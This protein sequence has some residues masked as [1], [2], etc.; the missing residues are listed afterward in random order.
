MSRGLRAIVGVIA[1]A[2]GAYF[3]QPWLVRIGVSL[4]LGAALEKNPSSVRRLQ[5]QSVMI[6]SAVQPQEIVYGR[7]R[8][9]GVLAW[10]DTSGTTNEYL[11][12]VIAV[13]EHEIDGYEKLWI[14]ETEIDIATEIDGSGY[15]TN[16]AFINADGTNLVKTG[17]YTGGPSQTADAELIAAFADWDS[18]KQGNDVAYFWVRLELDRSEGGTD[19][20][21][22]DANV[23]SQG[24]P[25]DLSVTL[26]GARVYDP[27][28]DSTQTSIPGA[29]THRADTPSTWEWSDNS[30][31]CRADY[32][33]HQRFGPGYAYTDIDWLTVAE[34]A[35]I[36]DELVDIPDAATQKRYTLNGVVSTVDNPKAIIESMA[37]ADHGVTLL[38]PDGIKLLVGSWQASSYT[39]DGSWLAGP[40]SVQSALQTDDA[41]N[42]VRG[43]Y[44]SAADNYALVEFAPRTASAY[45]TED[46]VGRIWSDIVL[47]F[48]NE[49]Y[50]AQRSAIIELK[51]S[52]QQ[53]TVTMQCNFR[54]MQIPLYSVVALDMEGFTLDT[55]RVIGKSSNQ[56]G[57]V[58]LQLREEVESDWTYTVPDLAVPPI[59]PTVTRNNGSPLPPTGLTASTVANG[60]QLGWTNA[61]M[62]GVSHIE[63]YGGTLN[64]RPGADLLTKTRSEQYLHIL[65]EGTVRYYWILARSENG[66]VSPWEPLSATGGVVGTAGAAGVDGDDALRYYI[67]PISGTAILNGTG[68]LTVEAHLVTGGVDAHLAA[69][70][71]KL[72][73]GTT[74]VTVANGYATGSDG[75]TG[76]FDAGDINGAAVVELKDGPAGTVLDTITLVDVYD[77]ADGDPGTAGEDAVYGY[78]TPS[79]PL[80][81]T[82]ASDQTT[83]TPTATTVDLTATFVLAGSNVAVIS[84]RI[85]RTAAGI[86]TGAPVTLGTE[87]NTARVTVVELD[88]T[89]Q[90][91]SV[92]FTYSFEGKT[93]VV[94]ETV[95][96]SMAGSKGDKGDTGDTGSIGLSIIQGTVYK[97]SATTPSTPSLGT[98]SYDF[99][100]KVLTPPS[101]WSASPPAADGNPMYATTTTFSSTDGAGTNDNTELWSTPTLFVSD[102]DDGVSAVVTQLTM[103]SLTVAADS[104]GT[105]YSLSALDGTNKADHEVFSGATNVT[106][107]SVQSI[108]GGTDFGSYWTKTQNGISMV[109]E[110][111]TGNYYLSGA[112]PAWTT[113]SETF[114]L[115]QTY[116]G[117]AYDKKF[118]VTKAKSGT[119][120]ATTT[121]PVSIQGRTVN[122][123]SA[124]GIQF[125]FDGDISRRTTNGGS[126]VDIG[127]WWDKTTGSAGDYS[128][129]LSVISSGGNTILGSSTESWLALSTTRNLYYNNG[130]GVQTATVSATIKHNTTGQE[131]GPAIYTLNADI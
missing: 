47:Q 16:S 22:P 12:F 7:T 109:A 25:R 131:Y 92:K 110:E 128:I 114:T 40:M 62:I 9:S 4:V 27:R 69:G 8:K 59:V 49:E 117:V 101:G 119:D 23:W 55:F 120:P 63:V 37:S 98:G 53:V 70:T 96:T 97:R 78:I 75:Y 113:D 35:D 57:I 32:L 102:G 54:A 2:V 122:G 112:S 90:A 19:P 99:T 5:E 21:N 48:T 65:P 81:W 20:E 26:R 61:S 118:T 39:I 60:V 14:D 18:T 51:K 42:G 116:G 85:T 79:G 95:I 10:F 28:L 72:Y 64:S 124:S 31:L 125:E 43:Q 15:V 127:D 67:K 66:L 126:F 80:S 74:E 24:W 107:S 115:R 82:R 108:V 123:T 33:R 68:E 56:N 94:T 46:G 84:H 29:G 3:K 93:F 86:L 104:D 52:R 88:E 129:W 106:A 6:R 44:M 91:M 77:G 34:Q 130:G 111:S 89:S 17:F 1:I 105:G 83:W 71:I 38:Q 50:A 45:E 73:V 13:V 30:V 58:T 76:V 41:Y 87:L 11:W 100:T 36:A 103:S 121:P